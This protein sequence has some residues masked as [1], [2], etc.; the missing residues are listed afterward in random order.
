MKKSFI[1]IAVLL[2]SIGVK[3]QY[4]TKQDSTYLIKTVDEIG[5]RK[6]TIDSL[7]TLNAVDS[8]KL[9]RKFKKPYPIVLGMSLDWSLKRISEQYRRENHELH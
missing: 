1:C 7:Q 9:C 6:Q 4:Y 2:L 5:I 3:A 8:L